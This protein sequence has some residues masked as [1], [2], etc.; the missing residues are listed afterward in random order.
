MPVRGVF[1]RGPRCRHAHMPPKKSAC[2][3][4]AMGAWE[5][6]SGR[7]DMNLRHC[8]CGSGRGAAQ[9]ACAQPWRSPPWCPPTPRM[10]R[11]GI[12][13]SRIQRRDG[14]EDGREERVTCIR[15]G[16]L[17]GAAGHGHAR[18]RRVWFAANPT[19]SHGASAVPAE[20]KL[21]QRIFQYVHWYPP[22]LRGRVGG[23][24]PSAGR[25]PRLQAPSIHGRR[26]RVSR[27]S[28]G[29]GA[30]APNVRRPASPGLGE[31][32]RLPVAQARE[33]MLLRWPP[34][35]CPP[36]AGRTRCSGPSRRTPTTGWWATS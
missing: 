27:A 6:P 13:A 33:P 9:E 21:S 7:P 34:C 4:G 20:G 24:L 23:E 32:A 30:A 2:V 19:R 28:Q 12:Y 5:C 18:G 17:R 14:M 10:D 22:P 26:R 15:F 11:G 25:I 35:G 36:R 31:P 16:A 3:P 8:L 1:S 29:G